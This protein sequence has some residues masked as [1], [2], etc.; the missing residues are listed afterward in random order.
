MNLLLNGMET[1]D[2]MSVSAAGLAAAI[3]IG[4]ILMMFTT[5]WTTKK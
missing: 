1:I 4:G 5:L 3:F 2:W